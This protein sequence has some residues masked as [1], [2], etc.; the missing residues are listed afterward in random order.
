LEQRRLTLQVCWCRDV[1]IDITRVGNFF[2]PFGV[3]NIWSG[4]RPLQAGCADGNKTG[5]LQGLPYNGG[6][7]K[8]LM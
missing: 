5:A 8:C 6:K 2:F 7:N 4:G 3:W 1:G